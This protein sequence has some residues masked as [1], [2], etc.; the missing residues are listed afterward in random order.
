MLFID[1][2]NKIYKYFVG[3]KM[4]GIIFEIILGKFN[5]ELNLV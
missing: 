3:L 2:F 4:F 1:V 5:I